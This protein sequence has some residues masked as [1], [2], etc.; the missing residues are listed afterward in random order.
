MPIESILLPHH[1]LL[2]RRLCGLVTIKDFEDDSVPIYQDP[3]YRPGTSIIVDA[4]RVADFNFG[5]RE[6]YGFVERTK[7]RLEAR[8][9]AVQV[10]FVGDR[11]MG[12]SIAKMF[13]SFTAIE[14]SLISVHTEF[15]M[16]EVFAFLEVP[17]SL[18]RR[19]SLCGMPLD[20]VCPEDVPCDLA[21]GCCRL[22]SN[23]PEGGARLSS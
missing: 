13:A 19:L 16:E 1:N 23:M 2:Y 20:V 17:F 6:M 5:F 10:F 7:Q 21:R 14:D 12:R 3:D 4:Q 8:K 18:M 9:A 22:R 15:D 11:I